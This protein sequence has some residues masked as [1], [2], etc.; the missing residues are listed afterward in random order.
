V[1]VVSA[2]PSLPDLTPLKQTLDR[3]DKSID[4]TDDMLPFGDARP[5]RW[6][7]LE[8]VLPADNI[9][10]D[11][12][13]AYANTIDSEIT[14]VQ[15]A[16]QPPQQGSITLGG[17]TSAIPITLENTGD[18]PLKVLL[19]ARSPKLQFPAGDQV[20]EIAPGRQRVDIPVVARSNGRFP[21]SVQIFTP[22][23]STPLSAPTTITV[24]S[25]ALT[26]RGQLVTGAFVLILASWWFQHVRRNRQRKRATAAG[27]AQQRHPA[28]Q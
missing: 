24:Q 13:R 5:D 23:G 14:A 21:V 18:T 27:L 2:E 20:H 9:S 12:Q 8:S 3:L 1:E 28:A 10:A 15:G 25:S 19:R 26:G 11:Q 17:R 6:R 16:I 4:V 7:E 22:D